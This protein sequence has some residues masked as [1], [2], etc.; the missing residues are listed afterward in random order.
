[1][2]CPVSLADL[3]AGRD[4]MATTLSVVATVSSEKNQVLKTVV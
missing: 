2:L 4:M 1:M 3:T